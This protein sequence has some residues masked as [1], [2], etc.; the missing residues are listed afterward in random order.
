VAQ[1]MRLTSGAWCADSIKDN[2]MNSDLSKNKRIALK[3]CM[4]G[5]FITEL[6]LPFA[7]LK[8]LD[9]IY[10]E[11]RLNHSCKHQQ[12]SYNSKIKYPSSQKFL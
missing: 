11:Q 9:V 4:Y 8:I 10:E 6:H 1:W 7:Q 5:H 3:V 12:L 2:I